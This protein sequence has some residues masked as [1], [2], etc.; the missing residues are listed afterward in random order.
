M[1]PIVRAAAIVG[2]TF[3]MSVGGLVAFAESA[4]GLDAGAPTPIHTLGEILRKD[5]IVVIPMGNPDRV[6]VDPPQ[7]L[8]I[9]DAPSSQDCLD[10][11]GRWI[12]PSTCYGVDY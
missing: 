7:V 12:A 4:K 5:A 6:P 2:T 10:M 3:A 9:S 8:V 11:G 1:S